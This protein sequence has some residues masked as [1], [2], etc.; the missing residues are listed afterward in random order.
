MFLLD[1]NVLSAIMATRVVPE[2]AAWLAQQPANLIFTATVCQAEIL[3]ELA[4][5]PDG[6]RRAALQAAAEAMF[7]DDLGGR[8]WPFDGAA[9]SAYADLFAARRASGRPIATV[10]LMIAGIARSRAATVVTRNVPDF[11]NC[12]LRIV[13]PWAAIN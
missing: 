1:T 3:A 10:D 2:V 11:D 13:N 12:G 8:I 4:I 9:A 7:A 5:L 6:R